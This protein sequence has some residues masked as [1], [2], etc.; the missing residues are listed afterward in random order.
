MTAGSGPMNERSRRRARWVDFFRDTRAGAVGLASVFIAMM[1]FAGAA[2]ISDHTV[3]VRQRDTLLAAAATASIATTRQMASLDSGLSQDE[4]VQELKPLA[5][6]YILANLTEGLRTS[7]KNTLEVTITPNRETGVVGIDAS[8][9]LGGA[10]VGRYLWGNLVTKTRAAGGAER[11]A[12]PVDLVLA[13]DVTASMNGSIHTRHANNVPQDQRRINVVRK[14]AQLLIDGLYD[15][16]GDTGHVSVGLVPFNTTVNVGATRQS[17][18]N[19]LGQGHKVIPDGFGPWRGCIEHRA[20]ANDLDLSL[21]TP[22]EKPFTSWFSP[23]TLKYRPTKRAE[24]ATEIG[25]AVKGENDWSADDPHMNYKPSPHSGCPGDEIIPLTTTRA[26]VDQAIANLQPWSGGGTMTH[27]GVVW[28]RRV[29]ASEW[30]S[31][32]GLTE[33]TEKL[34]G[35]KVLVLLTDGINDAYDNGNTYPGN[36]NHNRQKIRTGYGSQY[37]GYGRAGSGTAT[38]GAAEGYREGTR[39]TGLTTEND[40]RAVLDRIFL[41]ACQLAKDDGI[42][43][44]TVSAVPDDQPKVAELR[45]RLVTCATSVD[46]AFV[47]NSDP[48]GMQAAF[49]Q[50]GRMVQ[51]V[52]RTATSGSSASEQT[53]AAE[54][55]ESAPEGQ[56][57][58]E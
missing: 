48:E 26:T 30:R 11:V 36:Y 22:S 50:I 2:M 25:V 12:S 1:S 58:A 45:E 55:S 5:K 49:R 34:A 32:W 18:V 51:G 15:Q 9:N 56:V 21:D 46:H 20:M 57:A 52:R 10:I 37:T 19:D 41:D 8:A 6:R 43:V 42:T 28:G 54:S 31:A 3:L 35:Q 24:L 7:A 33:D 53:A 40:E 14:A 4:L 27:L 23:S 38:E 39:L 13:I 16:A 47:R 17:W 44:F 29:L